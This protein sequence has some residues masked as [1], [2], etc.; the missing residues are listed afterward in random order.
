MEQFKGTPG[1]WK[2]NEKLYDTIDIANIGTEYKTV[3]AVSAYEHRGCSIDETNSNAILISSAPELLLQAIIF[4]QYLSGEL[5]R[6]TD[7][8]LLQEVEKVI[9]KALGGTNQ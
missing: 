4:K 1:P 8:Y 3:C 2:V 6:E 5:E 9:T 7:S